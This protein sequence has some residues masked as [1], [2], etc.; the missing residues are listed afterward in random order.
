MQI[1]LLDVGKTV[2]IEFFSSDCAPC[3]ESAPFF[4]DMYEAWGAGNDL[5][6]FIGVSHLDDNGQ[7][8][9][10]I[11]QFDLS[12]PIIGIDGGGIE[13]GEDYNSGDFG[14]FYGYPTYAIIAPDGT[15][16]YDPR[17]DNIEQLVLLH[18]ILQT[19]TSS[20]TVSINEVVT[21]HI[22][23]FPNPAYDQLNIECNSK[24]EIEI[25]SIAGEVVVSDLVNRGSHFF[26]LKNLNA[27][28]YLVKFTSTT[29]VVTSKF[30]KY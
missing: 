11:D 4:Q 3:I 25:R 9:A 20:G 29:G 14:I 21:P 17:E 1:D 19:V 23:V 27:G 24:G 15:F 10:F 30:F 6:E 7:V 8:N 2:L 16:D 26:D 28:V 18:Q 12:Y 5:V 22:S 13:I